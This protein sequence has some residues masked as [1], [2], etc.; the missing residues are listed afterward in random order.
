MLIEI[1]II[2]SYRL[3]KK[4][5]N[6]RCDNCEKEFE[7]AYTRG[8][9]ELV[10]HFCCRKCQQLAYRKNGPL[11]E[12]LHSALRLKFGDDYRTIIG[13]KMV[14]AST[15]EQRKERAARA[16]QTVLKRYGANSALQ[17]AHVR[18]AALK[19]ASSSESLDKRK[20][21]T[22]ERFGVES[23]L[24]LDSVHSLANSPDACL[25]RHETMK[26]NGSYV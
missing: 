7:S 19:A 22:K 11:Y 9:S 14:A 17:I 5:L 10:Y 20:K 4:I 8:K 2:P 23:V 24:S 13:Q 26:R 6:L 15:F 16:R 21:T 12:R 3:P 1:R 25:K 18:A